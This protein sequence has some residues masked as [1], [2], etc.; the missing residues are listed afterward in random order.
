MVSI[1][2]S[3]HFVIEYITI[4]FVCGELGSTIVIQLITVEEGLLGGGEEGSI[5][6][7]C[8]SYSLT[9]PF[10]IKETINNV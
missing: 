7:T 8:C 6:G 1:D 10:K 9:H 2:T 5:K 3:I 4:S